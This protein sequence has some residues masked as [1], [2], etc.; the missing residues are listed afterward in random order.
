MNHQPIAELLDSDPFRIC[1]GDKLESVMNVSLV[2]NNGQNVKERRVRGNRES[3]LNDA[4]D[5]ERLGYRSAQSPF[6]DHI[7]TPV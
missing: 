7:A 1:Q 2:A 5:G 6:G 3:H 4:S